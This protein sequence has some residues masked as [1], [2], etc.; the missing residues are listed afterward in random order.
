M[1]KSRP[2]NPIIDDQLL[3][4]EWEPSI[5]IRVGDIFMEKNN[6]N[7]YECKFVSEFLNRVELVSIDDPSDKWYGAVQP[8]T[9]KFTKSKVCH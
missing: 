5:T 8:L 2:Y 6:K 4:I 1:I 7:K 9:A 3:M